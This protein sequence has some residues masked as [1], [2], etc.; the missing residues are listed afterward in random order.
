[1]KIGIHHREGSF[2]TQW[3]KY[4]KDKEIPFKIVNCYENNIMEQLDDCY[5]LMWHHHHTSFTDTLFAKGLLFS[6]QQSGKRVFPDF[7]TGWHFDDK[8]GQKY[9]L[10]SVNAPFIPTFVFYDKVEALAWAKNVSYPKVFKLRGGAGATN[11]KL[12]KSRSQCIRLINRA[13]GK[14]F[15]QYDPY[16]A[17]KDRINNFK[18]TKDI[19]YAINAVGSLFIRPEFSKIQHRE[20][21]YIYFQE[22]IPGNDFDVRLIVIGDKAYGM[23]RLVRKGDFRASGS[24]QFI[25]DNIDPTTLELA[26]SVSE[27]LKLQCTAF[28]F[29]Y[30]D[31]KPLIVEVSYGFGTKG[32]SKCKGYWDRDL[33][34]NEGSFDSYGWMVDSIISE[35]DNA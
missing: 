24:K 31:G 30:L 27:R 19:K 22:F 17:F 14:G 15:S 29:V 20:R 35:F 21:G 18:R 4:C 6:I 11:V 33:N 10:E 7:N 3:I 26:F 8:L 23:K 28:D 2:S 16:Q 1:M 5:A 32:S 34:F 13:F 12:V 25:Y 9:L